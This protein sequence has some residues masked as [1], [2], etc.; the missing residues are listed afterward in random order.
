[1]RDPPD[2]ICFAHGIVEV[3]EMNKV[4]LRRGRQ[5]FLLCLLILLFE[6][7]PR[8]RQPFAIG[9]LGFKTHVG[10]K[11]CQSRPVAR[12]TAAGTGGQPLF[13]GR[14]GNQGL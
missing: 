4:A 13:S 8:R 10:K 6:L 14:I 5:Y 7:T 2:E 12:Q 11:R 3:G 9:T 1:M